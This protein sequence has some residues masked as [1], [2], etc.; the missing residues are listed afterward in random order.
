MEI[1]S[2]PLLGIMILNFILSG[3]LLSLIAC[4]EGQPE[5]KATGGKILP[6]PEPSLPVLS[7]GD[8]KPPQG[9]KRIAADP[10]SFASWLRD[11]P[12]KKDK[13]VYLYN[14]KLKPNQS[15]QFAVVDISVGKKDLQQCADVVMR[16]RAEYLFAQNKYADIAFMDYSGKWYKWQGRDNRRAFD[17]YLQTVFG[18][19]GSASLE[20]QLMPVKNFNDIKAGDVFVQGGFPGHA[21]IVVDIAVNEKGKKIFML[22]QG[23]QPAQDIHVVVNPMNGT[24]SPWYEIMEEEDIVTPEWRFKKDN[25]KTWE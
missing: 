9:Y 21:M 13:S 24:L 10:A 3:L 20:K 16:L 23:Y 12:L 7:V 6:E 22:V 2:L 17:N 1:N 14:G 4:S 11:V 19:C 8:I 15:A 18:W 5:S 25:L